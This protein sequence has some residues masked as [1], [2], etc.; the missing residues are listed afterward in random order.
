MLESAALLPPAPLTELTEAS[1]ASDFSDDLRER[2]YQFLLP[3][4][5]LLDRKIDVRLVRTLWQTVEAMIRFRNRAHGLLLSELG[6]YLL[7]PE[8]APAGTKR[9]SN[10]LRCEKWTS[11]AIDD[12]LWQQAKESQAELA[13]K[14]EP[15]LILW[16]ESVIE[17]PES[18][19]AEGLCAV[20]SAKAAR[21]KRIKP[22]SSGSSPAQADQAR[23]LHTTCQSTGLCTGHPLGRLDS[24]RVDRPTHRCRHALVQHPGQAANRCPQSPV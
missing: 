21:L 23:L 15:A 16:D 5:T 7:S 9:L 18:L 10:L 22:G 17:K 20:R 11:A 6:S 24:D 3:L 4:L 2:L 13:G 19:K 12:F 14:G 1:P 8:H